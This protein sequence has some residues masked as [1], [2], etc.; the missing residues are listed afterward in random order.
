MKA[1]KLAVVLLALGMCSVSAIAQDDCTTAVPVP[2]PL[3]PCSDT[4]PTGPLDTG[5]P[6]NCTSGGGL[7]DVW[8]TFVAS[9]TSARIRTDISSTGTDSDY[10]IYA[11]DCANLGAPIGCSEDE[12][13]FLGNI[14]VG[15]L[16]P[17]NTYIIRMGTWGDFCPNGPYVVD[18]DTTGAV[19]GDG[20]LACDGSEACDDGNTTAGDGCD[21]L[22]QFEAVCGNNIVEVPEVCD[23]TDNAACGGGTCDVDCTCIPFCGN[24]IREVGE[25]CDGTDD[26]ACPGN[27]TA[28]CTCNFPGIPAVS[29]WGLVVLVLIGLA[30]GTVVF[31]RRRETVA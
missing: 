8:S 18:I 17:G 19:C 15:G 2:T 14:C 4:T 30:V 11:G 23:G 26:P 31:G 1:L 21:P 10:L 24:N 5:A 27:C 12:S 16:T 25:Q 7:L 9:T 28:G 22:C 6:P 29:E 3:D 13:G 20:A